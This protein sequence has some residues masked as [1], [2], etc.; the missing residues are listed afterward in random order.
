MAQLVWGCVVYGKRR[1][2]C[3]PR[4][5]FR[6]LGLGLWDPGFGVAFAGRGQSLAFAVCGAGLSAAFFIWLNF[7]TTPQV[8]WAVYPIFAVLWWPLAI[9][10]FVYKPRKRKQASQQ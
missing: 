7:A 5:G 8:I 2:N 6:A 9:Y 3:R 10:Y 1:E 4:L